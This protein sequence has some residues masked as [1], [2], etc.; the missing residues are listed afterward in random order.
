MRSHFHRHEA[1]ATHSTHTLHNSHPPR[2][3][4][5]ARARSG[6]MAIGA[7]EF[8]C[9]ESNFRRGLGFGSPVKATFGEGSVLVALLYFASTGSSQRHGTEFLPR[10]RAF[11]AATRRRDAPAPRAGRVPAARGYRSPP[12]SRRAGAVRASFAKKSALG[13]GKKRTVPRNHS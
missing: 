4:D 9:R 13:L 5:E 10:L 12:V 2:Y 6:A 3:H 1:L 8:A 7:V 11:P